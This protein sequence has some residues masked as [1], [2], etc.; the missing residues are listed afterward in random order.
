MNLRSSISDLGWVLDDL[1]R[2]PHTL[3]ALLL[4]ADGLRA[5]SSQGVDRD[6]AD[7]L[8]A[9]VS[10]MQALSGQAAEFANCENEPW[11]LTMIQYQGGY[12]FIMA[13]GQGT[14]LSVSASKDADVEAVSYAMEKTID[15]LGQEMNLAARNGQDGTS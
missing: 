12:I 6:M 9:A 5:A 11:E 2:L 8:S 3:H 4:S 13:A 10:G 1:V 15:R 7:R 14:Y